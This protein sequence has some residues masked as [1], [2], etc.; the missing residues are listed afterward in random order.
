MH[1]VIGVDIGTSSCRAVVFS[2]QL[3]QL[4]QAG[5]EYPIYS[6]VPGSAEQDPDEI[7]D[8]VVEV[9]AASIKDSGLRPQQIA[10]IGFAAVKH[11]I[12][13]LDAKQKRL[14]RAWAW[15]DLRSR[16]QAQALLD[17]SPL[18]YQQ[19]GCPIHSI[20][21]PAK[22]KHLQQLAALWGQTERIVSIKEYVMHRLT[23]QWAA[24][25]SVASAT[26]IMNIA[27][28]DWDDILLERLHLDRR[29]LNPVVEPTTILE[30]L[31]PE[32]ARCTGLPRDIPVIIGGSDGTLS[33]VGA[34]AVRPG[35]MAL[36]VGTSGAV[37]EVRP[38]PTLHPD[39]KTWCYYLADRQWVSGGAV[40][41]GGNTLQWFRDQLED[42]TVGFSDLSAKAEAAPP[43]SSGLLFL[44]YLTGERCPHWNYDAR[45]V[46]F[47][48]HMQST[49]SDM[50]RS[51]MEGV[52]FQLFSIYEALAEVNG[53]PH[54]IRCSGG[55]AHSGVWVQIMADVFGRDMDVP[56]FSEGSSFGAAAL[57]LRALGHV[58]GLREAA[59]MIEPGKTVFHDPRRHRFYQG[60]Y[61]HNRSLYHSVC[62]QFRDYQQYLAAED[63]RPQDITIAEQQKNS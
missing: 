16:P 36:M 37:R 5:K 7:Y 38:E 46:F 35:V 59:D 27:H 28:R 52:A 1:A 26:G 29:L 17:A 22:I 41:N 25:A 20:Y 24:D 9:I 50:V 19:S 45:G 11:S 31:T 32:A 55:L 4:A 42:V 3:Q 15:P 48:L 33:N 54:L 47:G 53:T 21:W 18:F 34:G 30:G 60:L 12:I 43:G 14:S 56:A 62:Q 39:Q 51:I 57:V 23:G 49:K 61:R 6:P 10:G 58:G 8:A 40:N 44:P 13:P 2:L 63:Q